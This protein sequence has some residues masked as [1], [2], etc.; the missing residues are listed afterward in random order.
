[1]KDCK[2]FAL[3]ETIVALGL[4]GVVAAVFIGTIGTATN[5]T[6]VADEQVTAESLVRGEIEYVK[7]YTYQYD[8]TEYPVD[9][10]LDVPVGWSMPNPVVEALHGTDDG[11]QKVTITIQRS[12]EEKFSAL[13]YKVDR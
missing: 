8:A 1:M 4:L 13:I 12:G 3:I 6:I 10:T 2:G 11:I 7:G 9:P 5:A